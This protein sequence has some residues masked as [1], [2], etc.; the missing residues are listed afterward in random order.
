MIGSLHEGLCICKMEIVRQKEITI[1][2]GTCVFFDL[3]ALS[4][5]SVCGHFTRAG[6]LLG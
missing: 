4:G 2:F 3:L 5:Q 1:L 6:L